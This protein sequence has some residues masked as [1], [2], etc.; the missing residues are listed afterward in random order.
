MG[1]LSKDFNRREFACKDNC[2]Y[3]SID[4]RVVRMTQKIRDVLGE[5]VKVNSACRCIKHNKAVGGVSESFHTKGLAAD[6]SCKSGS[7]KLFETIKVMFE[8]GKL[9]D[10]EYCRR[11]ASKNFVHIDC[12]KKRNG[13]FVEGN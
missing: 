3:D 6:L 11:Y 9:N 8:R 4:P 12:G 13:R 10:L 7:K 1:D 5:P 2:G